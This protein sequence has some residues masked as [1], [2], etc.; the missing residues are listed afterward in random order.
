MKFSL[1]ELSLL[2]RILLEASPNLLKL[3]Y[4]L[5][6]SDI[7]IQK[8]KTKVLNEL[9]NQQ[10]VNS[11]IIENKLFQIISFYKDYMN[12]IDSLKNTENHLEE[13]ED[14]VQGLSDEE[15]RLFIRERLNKML[16]TLNFE[17]YQ[18]ILKKYLRIVRSRNTQILRD[19]QIDINKLLKNKKQ[20]LEEFVNTVNDSIVPLLEDNELFD[21]YVDCKEI[22]LVEQN[23]FILWH[24]FGFARKLLRSFISSHNYIN[25]YD[26]LLAKEGERISIIDYMKVYDDLELKANYF[27]KMLKETNV[28][29][30]EDCIVFY[31]NGHEFSR[32]NH[33]ISLKN[34]E[35]FE[36][37]DNPIFYPAI[38]SKNP[39]ER[40]DISKI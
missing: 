11:Q 31:S 30:F 34:A 13:E 17:G 35:C 22:N 26:K 36:D 24:L 9:E 37:N 8:C 28:Y 7:L 6:L 16:I 38:F 14:N 20:N 5:E 40:N 1:T 27:M 23:F 39:K 32:Q 4:K 15:M 18:V 19:S 33:L 29:N 12:E 21:L 10:L 25:F 3:N 2:T